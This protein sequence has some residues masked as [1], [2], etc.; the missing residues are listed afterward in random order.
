[1]I[2]LNLLEFNWP[3][4]VTV[5]CADY[6]GREIVLAPEGY[7]PPDASAVVFYARELAAITVFGRTPE[8]RKQLR[9]QLYRLKLTLGS[10]THTSVEP[11]L[12]DN[13][14]RF[15]IVVEWERKDKIKESCPTL[16]AAWQAWDE[17]QREVYG[18]ARAFCL[19]AMRADA[20]R[21]TL[22]HRELAAAWAAWVAM[23]GSQ[24]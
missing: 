1:M 22:R 20:T 12:A 7:Q 8:E 21:P 15:P 13:A 24:G 14:P 2:D 5:A 17:H 9:D 11:K 10:K 16:D 18:K 23:G 3:A 4:V 19:W 6:G